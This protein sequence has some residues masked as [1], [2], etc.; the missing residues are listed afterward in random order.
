ML[1]TWKTP[2]THDVTHNNTIYKYYHVVRYSHGWTFF[3]IVSVKKQTRKIKTIERK[4]I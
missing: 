1:V 2:A 3:S 4:R